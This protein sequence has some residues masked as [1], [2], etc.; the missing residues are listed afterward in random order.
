MSVSHEDYTGVDGI[1]VTVGD[2]DIEQNFQVTIISGIDHTAEKAMKIYTHMG[3][4]HIEADATIEIVKV[5]SMSGSLCMTEAPASESAI[6]NA[7]GLKGIYVVEVQ[8]A[9]SVKRVK[10]RL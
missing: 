5:Y 7:G 8:T 1:T 10:V 9:G 6:I 4:I 2:E 3:N